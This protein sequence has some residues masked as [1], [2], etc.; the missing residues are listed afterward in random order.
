VL[1]SSFMIFHEEVLGLTPLF[2]YGRVAFKAPASLLSLKLLMHAYSSPAQRV[3]R[4]VFVQVC[5][6]PSPCNYQATTMAIYCLLG[7]CPCVA[8]EP[9][10][11]LCTYR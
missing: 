5:M 6:F 2:W 11:N 4:L 7:G 3:V 1:C 10:N 8:T 9:Y